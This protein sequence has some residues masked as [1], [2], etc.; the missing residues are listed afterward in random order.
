MD[1]DLEDINSELS[2]LK[3]RVKRLEENF[4]NTKSNKIE[5]TSDI[6]SNKTENTSLYKNKLKNYNLEDLIGIK[7]LGII[8]GLALIISA[9]FMIQ[10]AISAGLIGPLGRIIIATLTGISIIIIGKYTI[11]S[12]DISPWC[13]IMIG[14][15]YIITY[16]SIYGLSLYPDVIGYSKLLIL[17]LISFA[18]V[19]FLMDSIYNNYTKLSTVSILIVWV[20]VLIA[21]GIEMNIIYPLYIIFA[22]TITL[23][24]TNYKNWIG[25]ILISVIPSYLTLFIFIEEYD[26]YSFAGDMYESILI[27]SLFIFILIGKEIIRFNS[28]SFY[29]NIISSLN[30]MGCITLLTIIYHNVDNIL[31]LSFGILS[32]LFV[33]IIVYSIKESR[34]KVSIE[35]FFAFFTISVCLTL[36]GNGFIRTVILAFSIILIFIT[37]TKYK[38]IWIEISGHVTALFLFIDSIRL[39]YYN[40]FVIFSF[41]QET[42]SAFIFGTIILLYY[43]LSL[44][45]KYKNK[46]DSDLSIKKEKVS[47]FYG[48]AGTVI[49]IL[50]LDILFTGVILSLAWGVVGFI[51]IYVGWMYS[52]P[53]I[54]LQGISI[55]LLTTS[56]VFIYDTSGLEPI[57]RIFSFIVLGIILLVTSY[58][59]TKN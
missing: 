7:L 50:L 18:S 42:T 49:L 56:K 57:P 3:S 34:K 5:N 31:G 46:I 37:S 26:L 14:T 9:I 47:N 43:S 53:Q 6:Q 36:I 44:I 27:L 32:I 22:L 38:N 20:T 58:F 41:Q 39:V 2:D 8:G 28:K 55:L 19:V 23:F 48:W 52:I 13:H 12:Y 4:D 29:I 51:S 24:V 10:L 59:Y 35:P 1:K 30:L 16:V 17:G 33:G 21:H 11:E 40:E 45:F 54:R 25:P 15:G